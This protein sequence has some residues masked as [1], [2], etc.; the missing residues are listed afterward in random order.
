MR[1][2]QFW[3]VFAAAGAAA[4]V[5]AAIEARAEGELEHEWRGADGGALVVGWHLTSLPGEKLLVSGVDV[6]ARRRADE[7]IR[8]HVQLLSDLADASPAL[9][10]VV[11]LDGRHNDDSMNQAARD[12]FGYEPA[13]LDRRPFWDVWVPPEDRATAEAAIRAAVAGRPPE[14]RES[15]WITKGGER[16]LVAWSCA[17]MPDV[18]IRDRIV[19][20][21]GIDV[22]ERRRMLDEQAALRR[23]ATLVA[24]DPDPDDLLQAVTREVGQLFGGDTATIFR[25]VDERH[26][27]VMGG[28]SDSG[29]R[30]MEPGS[31]R[32]LDGDTAAVRVY[33]T[34]APA[35]VDDYRDIDGDFAR[36]LREVG[37]L[38][39]I[40]APVIVAGA[41]WGAISASSTHEHHFPPG[42]ESRLGAFASLVAQAIA[43]ADA[44]HELRRAA[45]RI[46]EA[47]DAERRRLERNLHDGAQQRLVTLSLSLRLAQNRLH[48]DPDAARAILDNASVDLSLAL[49]EL[50]ELARGLHPTILADRG[51]PAAL[52][53]LAARTAIPVEI[54]LMIDVRLPGSVEAA[55]FYV[56]AEALTNVAK[57]A[58]AGSAH[59]RLALVDGVAVIEIEDDGVGGADLAGGSG[60]PGLRDRVE[61]L[62]GKLLLRSEA[63]RGTLVRAEIPIARED[64]P[65]G[66][67]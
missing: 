60:L 34:Q 67:A 33:R 24:G 38:C 26:V 66:V 37:L 30:S 18:G 53:G 27:T 59:V 64:V 62:D 40:A 51:L 10:V 63:G 16:R 8:L 44:R 31:E 55:L 56:A 29:E 36:S 19:S 28:W 54:D 57:Y 35:R 65:V 12:A 48:D 25:Y 52:T 22:T 13:E 21:N 47:G 42:A 32:F 4:E 46:V 15:V 39:T 61:S 1:G 20:I 6:T 43:N 2:R 58:E 49:E 50:R 41:L 17:L 11:N 7:N 3:D 45:A 14:E 5:R 23:V 9:L